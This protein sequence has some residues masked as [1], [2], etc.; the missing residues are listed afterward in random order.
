MFCP[1]PLDGFQDVG[2]VLRLVGLVVLR[3]LQQH[4]VHVSGRVL[5]GPLL[6]MSVHIKGHAHDSYYVTEITDFNVVTVFSTCTCLRTY[7]KI[8][9]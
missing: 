5:G 6:S 2:V 1:S 8:Q 4:L 9:F 7:T 3:V